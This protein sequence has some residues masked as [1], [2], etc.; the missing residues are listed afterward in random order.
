MGILT[1]RKNKKFSYTPRYYKQ[2]GEGSPYSIK[3]KFDEYRTTL[4]TPK[5]VKDKFSQAWEEY[6]SNPK[7]SANKRILFI[8]IVLVVLFLFFIEFDFSIFYKN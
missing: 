5:G 2:D 3:Q 6:R 1:R 8:G 4:E 7:S